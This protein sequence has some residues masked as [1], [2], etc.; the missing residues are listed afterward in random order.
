VTA[1]IV[2]LGLAARPR[3][4][5]A[6]RRRLEFDSRAAR[7]GKTD[8]NRLLRRTRAVFSLADVVYFLANE[9]PRLR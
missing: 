1:L 4:C 3:G 6:P 7:L 8:R 2:T 5:L 9:L